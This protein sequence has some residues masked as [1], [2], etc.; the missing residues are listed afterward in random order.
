MKFRSIELI[1]QLQADVR[2]LLLAAEYLRQEDP[3]V[4]SLQPE[5][6]QWSVAQVLEHLNSYGRYYL[7]AIRHSFDGSTRPTATWFRPGWL[8]NY[9]TKIM[10]P[11]TGGK[12]TNK[13]KAPKNHRPAPGLDAMAVTETFISQQHQ[14]LGLLEKAKGKDIGKTRTP[15][16]I[17]PV[18]K[19]KAGDTFRFLVAHEQRHFVQVANA[20]R[21]VNSKAGGGAAGAQAGEGRLA[22][23]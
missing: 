5:P 15:I 1:E 7:P 23:V 4:L 22:R 6:G 19:L 3:S 2:Q 17:L 8:G 20:L 13:M 10:R 12:V 14:L 18:I 16:S 11:G 21:Q 9:F